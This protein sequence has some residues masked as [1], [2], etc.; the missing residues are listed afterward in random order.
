MTE[1]RIVTGSVPPEERVTKAVII[2]AAQLKDLLGL[3][4][5]GAEPGPEKA[6]RALPSESKTTTRELP[7]S[8]T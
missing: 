6:Q 4:L 3:T 8:A 7:V 2:A 5:P 1:Q